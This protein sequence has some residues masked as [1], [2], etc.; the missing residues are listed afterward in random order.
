[1]K[2]SGLGNGVIEYGRCALAV[3][4]DGGIGLY[5]GFTEMGQGLLTVLTQCAAEVTGLPSSLFPA[6]ASTQASSS[7]AARPPAR[8]APSWPAA[9]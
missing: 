8:A 7:A 1:M 2:N 5:T 6:R 9:P 4:P 3:E